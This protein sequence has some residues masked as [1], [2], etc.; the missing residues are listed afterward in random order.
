MKELVMSANNFFSSLPYWEP[1]PS[2]DAVFNIS[3]LCMPAIGE[4]RPSLL[5]HNLGENK[6]NLE[7]ERILRIPSISRRQEHTYVT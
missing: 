4:N 7:Q 5:L 1:D 2:A 6:T 3:K